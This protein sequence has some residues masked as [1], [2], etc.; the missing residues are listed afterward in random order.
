M[1]FLAGMLAPE[2]KLDKMFGF[3]FK[4]AF[5]TQCQTWAV[6]ISTGMP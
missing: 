2:G 5:M 1:S 3:F 4:A 6:H